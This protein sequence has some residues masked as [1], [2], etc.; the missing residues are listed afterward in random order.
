M[1]IMTEVHW[2]MVVGAGLVVL[3]I[4]AIVYFD[5]R[6]DDDEHLDGAG[7]RG[8]PFKPR[9]LLKGIIEANRAEW[10]NPTADSRLGNLLIGAAAHLRMEPP[11]LPDGPHPEWLECPTFP[12]RWV[13]AMLCSD[14][15][16]EIKGVLMVFH[17]QSGFIF[18]VNDRDESC[19]RDDLRW[20]VFWPPELPAPR[21]TATRQ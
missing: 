16:W 4:F 13:L 9:R 19:R 5:S 8:G 20:Q 6:H 10:N 3:A 14:G 11:D 21:T 12:G 15:D 18:N 17:R 7:C 1:E 2:T